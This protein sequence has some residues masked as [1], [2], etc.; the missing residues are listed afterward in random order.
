MDEPILAAAITIKLLRVAMAEELL[1]VMAVISMDIQRHTAALK[2][3]VAVALAE[4]EVMV[5]VKEV[6]TITMEVVPTAVTVE[7]D[8]MAEA[9]DSHLASKEGLS[10][11][12]EAA[13]L[14]ISTHHQL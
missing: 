2:L 13:V 6:H 3:L 12:E 4:A 1:V 9:Q 14:A 7:M 8:Y 11:E 5:L 10:A